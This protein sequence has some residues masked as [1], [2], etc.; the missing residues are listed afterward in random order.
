MANRDEWKLAAEIQSSEISRLNAEADALRHVNSE[1]G[2]D[3][4]EAGDEIERLRDDGSDSDR[5]RVQITAWGTL[6][7]LE[8]AEDALQARTARLIREVCRDLSGFVVV[9]V[10]D[11]E[12]HSDVLRISATITV[13]RPS[14]RPE[15]E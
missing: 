4:D 2:G 6:G 10:S 15:A 11:D 8:N 14:T 7:P 3:L 5:E 1:L 12:D 13:V 9:E